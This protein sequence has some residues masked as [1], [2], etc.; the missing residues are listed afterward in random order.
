[1][2]CS[3]HTGTVLTLELKAWDKKIEESQTR[4]IIPPS[5]DSGH[6]M[7]SWGHT[8]F[9]SRRHRFSSLHVKYYSFIV[10]S[11]E[12]LQRHVLQP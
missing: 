8:Q 4:K 12:D 7:S 9:S 11:T 1:M 6:P 5:Q 2:A 10:T 3:E